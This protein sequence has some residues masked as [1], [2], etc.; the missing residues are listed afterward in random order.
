MNKKNDEKLHRDLGNPVFKANR[1]LVQGPKVVEESV[2]TEHQS[3]HEEG[4][5][6]NSWSNGLKGEWKEKTL[7][8][9]KRRIWIQLY[10]TCQLIPPTSFAKPTVLTYRTAEQ[11]REG[12]SLRN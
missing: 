11:F 2:A 10:G 5:G 7:P 6:T 9:F 3:A 12:R 1:C 8:S 4:I